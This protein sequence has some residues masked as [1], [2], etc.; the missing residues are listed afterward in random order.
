ML[1]YFAV[2]NYRSIKDLWL[3]LD[4]V[5]VLVGANGCGKSNLYRALMLLAAA[6]EGDLAHKVA[7]EGGL[8]SIRFSGPTSKYFKSGLVKLAMRT[9]NLN[10]ELTI[11]GIPPE[12]SRS[13][14]LFS[15]DIE[16]KSEIFS[17]HS[18]SGKA[19]QKIFQRRRQSAE[20]LLASGGRSEYTTLLRHNRS[21]LAEIIDPE[22]YPALTE[23]REELAGWRFY[24]R[25]RT[26]KE[27]PARQANFPV[28]T[29]MLNQDGSNLA[30]TV[31]TIF[32]LGDKEQFLEA[33]E[34]AF[35]R[36][37]IHVE[38]ERLGLTLKVKYPGIKRPLDLGELSEGTLQY[39]LLLAAFHSLNRPSFMVL[40]E[41]EMSIHED[42]ME[43]LAE[44]IVEA[45]ADS[46][47]W[48]TTHSKLLSD[49]VMDFGG[50]SEIELDRDNGATIAP[51]LGL[52]GYRF[53]AEVDDA[54]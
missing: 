11:G 14:G 18:F 43:P 4:R 24:H 34:R 42:L 39:L 10:Y 28:A 30:A 38:Q 50:Y 8:G 1:N 2:N 33:F 16:I 26:D 15:K 19:P 9:E 23:I 12:L 36:T 47:I 21:V 53:E 27:A 45:A 35:P 46:Q 40:N 13:P 44:L 22:S 54:D 25:F 5:T 51:A 48:V 6:A 7:E 32:E 49:Y 41:P 31:A 3:K 52:G 17:R 29:R 37:Y 20:G